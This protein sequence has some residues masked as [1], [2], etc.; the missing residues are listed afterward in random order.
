MDWWPGFGVAAH[1]C[2]RVLLLS[3]RWNHHSVQSVYGR[4]AQLRLVYVHAA[5]QFHLR[6]GAGL[7]CLVVGRYL[8]GNLGL[9]GG[10]RT[11]GVDFTHSN[12]WYDLWYHGPNLF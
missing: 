10:Y 8:R 12:Q 7:G 4:G 3:V 6:A 2:F 11:G 1:R 5:K 9:V